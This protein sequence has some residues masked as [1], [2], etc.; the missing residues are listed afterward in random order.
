MRFMARTVQ[1]TL[2]FD[3]IQNVGVFSSHWLQHRLALEPEWQELREDAEA[4]LERLAKL[5]AQQRN[6]VDKY[7]DEQGLEEGFIQPVLR[8]L[9]WKLKY[10]TWLQG[11]EPDYALFPDDSALDAGLAADRKS[12]DF[13]APA[14]VVADSKAW[15]ISLD[16]PSQV[17][18]KREYPPQQIEWYLDRSGVDWG[19]LTNGMLWRLIPRHLGTRQRRYQTYLEADLKRI[20]DNWTTPSK[21][22]EERAEKFNQFLQFYLFFG[23][24]GF[25]ETVQRKSVVRR[26]QEGSSEY[27]IGV[28][29]GLK[30]QTF[31]ALRIC[32]EG[33]L[34]FKANGLDPSADLLYCREQ[35]F[36]LLCR[37]LFILFA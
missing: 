18:N 12:H 9:G 25:Q 17:N 8:E 34:A 23:P 1:M 7:G 35:S 37:L 36:T 10:Q 28:S 15:H 3:P 24:A 33:F 22:V 2:P 26:A 32:I 4:V 21:Y 6:R 30:G 29:E 27:F 31:E 14:K 5:W 11:R 16:R 20:L 19:I 13:W